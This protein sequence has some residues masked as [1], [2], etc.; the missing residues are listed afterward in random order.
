MIRLSPRLAAVAG[1]VPVGMA[2]A[3]IGTDHG[4]LPAYLVAAGRVPRA[5]AADVQAGPLEVARQTVAGAGLSDRIDLRLG[6]GLRVLQPGEAA[7]ITIC[8]MGGPLI[9]EILAAGPLEGVR[10]LVLQP[11]GGEEH[12]RAWLA[13]HGWR[14]TD[15]ELVADGGRIYAVLVA[16]P[17]A[18]TL[19]ET[20]RLVG[21]FLLQA[22]GPLFTAHVSALLAQARQAYAGAQRSDRP[23]ARERAQGLAERIA[24]L[25][26]VVRNAGTNRGPGRSDH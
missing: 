22:G 15:E 13:G 16:E 9:C 3:D 10:R 23:V 19:T 21:P 7:C 25:E 18:M 1:H 6:N 26:E 17:G 14:L 12:V 8:G 2:L 20:E 24:L 11:M 4:Y 5:V